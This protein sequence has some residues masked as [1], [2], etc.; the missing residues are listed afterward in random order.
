MTRPDGRRWWRT[1]L[2]VPALIVL[3]GCQVHT[4]VAI[5]VRD[6]GTG[7]VEVAVALDE[8][9]AARVPELA[10]QLEVGD[11]EATGWMVTGPALEGDGRT[12]IRA[13]KPF[14]S[15]E[16]AG[17]VLE[18]VTGA[19]GPFR[20]LVVRRR[21]SV[22][23]DRWDV[24]ATIDLSD[25]LAGFSD[26]ALRERLDGT[27]IGLSDE[28]VAVQAGRPLA[29]VVT[30]EVAVTLPGEAAGNG[31]TEGNRSAW[32]PV[33]GERL[34]ISATGTRL[35]TTALLWLAAAATAV[36]ALVVV[37]TRRALAR[38]RRRGPASA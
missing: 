25:G 35:Q 32:E 37:V 26:D 15:P 8:D 16:Q 13:S 29:E 38:H 24:T 20:D 36:V 22:V 11:L 27:N 1:V 31:V 12:W 30:F 6:D 34:D 18:Q 4:R 23:Q 17:V 7:Q 21:P 2:L 5:D 33:L 19:S 9:A 10:D 3:S 28:E 14:D